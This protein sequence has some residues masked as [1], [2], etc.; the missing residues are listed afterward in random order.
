MPV[1]SPW[2]KLGIVAICILGV[3]LGI[4]HIYNMG[5]AAGKDEVT[6]Q[7]L[8]A[9]QKLQAA[10][11]KLQAKSDAAAAKEAAAADARQAAIMARLNNLRLPAPVGKPTSALPKDCLFDDARVKWGNE[12]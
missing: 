8:L 3:T 2:V 1:L 10:Q 9:N 7:L 6:S 5:F 4:L 12:P 11:D